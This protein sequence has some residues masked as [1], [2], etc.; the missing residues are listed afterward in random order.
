MNVGTVKGVRT[1]SVQLVEME[2]VC[3]TSFCRPGNA[4]EQTAEEI[5]WRTEKGGS[6]MR[7]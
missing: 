4:E 1:G 7:A 5:A 3:V 6:E 2:K